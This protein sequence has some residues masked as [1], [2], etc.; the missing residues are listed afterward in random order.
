MT[1]ARRQRKSRPTGIFLFL[2]LATF[3]GCFLL[4]PDLTG[5]STS[6]RVV[7]SWRT[8]LALDGVDPVAYFTDSQPLLGRPEF[9]YR[10]DGVV[11]RFR[12]DANRSAFAQA[13]EVY[14]PRYGGHDPVAVARGVAVSGNPL[15]WVVSHQRL[16]LFFSSAARAQ[17]SINSDKIVAEAEAK[18]PDVVVTLV[19]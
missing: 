11:W 16:Y 4:S 8:G 15:L 6:E 14:M 19:R 13:P 10:Y 12:N 9:E 3:V 17:F 5:A 2:G 18:W 1:S 7:S